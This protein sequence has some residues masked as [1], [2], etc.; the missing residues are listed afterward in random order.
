MKAGF[1]PNYVFQ[2]T[3]GYRQSVTL[4]LSALAL[5]LYQQHIA[6]AVNIPTANKLLIPVGPAVTTA[7]PS[8]RSTQ[9]FAPPE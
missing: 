1:F 2:C 6:D 8:V 3:G 4:F 5:H 7:A 9:R